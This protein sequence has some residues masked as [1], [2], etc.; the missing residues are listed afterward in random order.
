MFTNPS[1]SG[2]ARPLKVTIKCW[3]ESGNTGSGLSFQAFVDDITFDADSAWARPT[4]Y[5]INMRNATFLESA[6]NSFQGYTNENLASGGYAISSLTENFDIKEDGSNP[7]MEFSKRVAS[8]VL[9]SQ[10]VS[11]PPGMD[12]ND[13]YLAHGA[14]ATRALLVGESKGE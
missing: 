1:V 3:D 8:E 4:T 12:I 6:N 5:T 2:V 9:N 7:G 11:L 13:Y 10:I 14:E